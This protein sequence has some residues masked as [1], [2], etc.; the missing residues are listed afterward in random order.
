MTLSNQVLMTQRQAHEDERDWIIEH[1][2]HIASN[3][4]GDVI[5][6]VDDL[7]QW[8]LD[9]YELPK[10]IDPIMDEYTNSQFIHLHS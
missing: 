4:H 6:N 5:I 10:W 9:G 7:H 1:E 2:L 8:I 3:E